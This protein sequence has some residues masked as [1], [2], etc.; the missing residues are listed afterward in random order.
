MSAQLLRLG[1]T[2]R[3]VLPGFWGPPATRRARQAAWQHL[4]TPSERRGE[5]EELRPSGPSTVPA[6][7]SRIAR[8][9]KS[10][11]AHARATC[12]TSA[13]RVVHPPTCLDPGWSCPWSPAVNATEVGG[14]TLRLLQGASYITR[15]VEEV[16]EMSTRGCSGRCLGVVWRMPLNCAGRGTS[17]VFNL[18]GSVPAAAPA[19]GDT[20]RAILLRCSGFL[21]MEEVR[22]VWLWVVMLWGGHLE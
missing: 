9:G 6:G 11:Q 19:A 1:P 16:S 7:P 10:T 22:V 13:A 18:K 3:A 20:K 12:V 14:L 15:G 8:A 21:P 2:A 5:I 17:C 4:A